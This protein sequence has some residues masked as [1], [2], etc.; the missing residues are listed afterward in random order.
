METRPTYPQGRVAQVPEFPTVR[1]ADPR[2][3]F[4]EQPALDAIVAELPTPSGR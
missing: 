2:A 1:I 4:F 3:G